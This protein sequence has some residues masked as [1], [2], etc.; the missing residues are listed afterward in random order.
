MSDSILH[1]LFNVTTNDNNIIKLEIKLDKR[2]YINNEVVKII[3]N[4]TTTLETLDLNG[5]NNLTDEGLEFIYNLTNL[6]ELYL[7]YCSNLT[8]EG[9]EFISNLT[10]LKILNLCCC[11]N[12]TGEG[13]KSLSYMTN[14]YLVNLSGCENLTL[15]DI[16]SLTDKLINVMTDM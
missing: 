3:S 5:C 6:K 16:K 7:G 9:L 2:E 1:D 10:N 12:L 8:D 13:I 4:L 11:K 14:L 15:E